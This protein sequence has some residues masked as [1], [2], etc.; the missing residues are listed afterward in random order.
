MSRHR[1]V[2]CSLNRR[3]NDGVSR[4]H[5]QIYRM[6]G[7]VRCFR[8][9]ANRNKDRWRRP[10][11]SWPPDSQ[12]WL[13]LCRRNDDGVRRVLRGNKLAASGLVAGL[14]ILDLDTAAALPPAAA[15]PA[16]PGLAAGADLQ[17]AGAD[18][19]ETFSIW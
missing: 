14:A 19:R 5:R 1:R 6:R 4:I 8:R 9:L 11:I 3:N 13:G 10:R 7:D 2:A 18:A 17:Q 16:I 15:V 12:R